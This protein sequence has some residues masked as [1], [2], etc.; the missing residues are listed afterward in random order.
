MTEPDAPQPETPPGSELPTAA[1]VI[2]WIIWTLEVIAF[3]YLFGCA[4][5]FTASSTV[6]DAV[7]PVIGMLAGL[8]LFIFGLVLSFKRTRSGAR[9]VFS[10]AAVIL[11]AAFV[12]FAGCSVGLN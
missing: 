9:R 11:A 1:Q 10:G 12:I 2:I 7:V 6:T 5:L 4:V 3:A 8:A